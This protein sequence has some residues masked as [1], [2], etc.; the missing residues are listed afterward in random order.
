MMPKIIKAFRMNKLKYFCILSKM[1]ED[2]YEH[3]E[4]Q[5]S[6]KRSEGV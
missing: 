5:D 2:K 3:V 4:S 6:E 1:I